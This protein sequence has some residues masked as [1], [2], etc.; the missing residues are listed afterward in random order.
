[1]EQH[2]YRVTAWWTSGRAGIAKSQKVPTAIHFTAPAEFGGDPGRWNPEELL[3]S[4]VAGCFTTTFEAIAKYSSLGYADLEV[5]VEG[6]IAKSDSGFHFTE[7]F[8]RPKLRI[9]EERDLR[10]AERVLQKSKDLCL[11][12]RALC[13]PQRFETEVMVGAFERPTIVIS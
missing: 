1:M 7:I 8:I 11:V 2:S 4:A 12:S 13:V 9:I 5:A 6:C 10:L 3:L